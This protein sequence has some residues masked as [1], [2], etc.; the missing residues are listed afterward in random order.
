MSIEL[1]RLT[2]KFF[3]LNELQKLS[4]VTPSI[5][6]PYPLRPISEERRIVHECSR[7]LQ[8]VKINKIRAEI[9]AM[10]ADN[11]S[12]CRKTLLSEKCRLCHKIVF[13]QRKHALEPVTN[14]SDNRNVRNIVIN[15]H[16]KNKRK[17]HSRERYSNRKYRKKL[18]DFI[19]NLE[20]RTIVNLSSTD[21][22]LEDLFALEIGHGFI[23]SL[24]NRSVEEEQLILE[25]FRFIDRIGIAESQFSNQSDNRNSR[26]N[27]NC[28]LPSAQEV[29]IPL[30][31]TNSLLSDNDSRENFVRDSKRGL[32]MW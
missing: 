10:N 15:D 29:I 18:Q 17:I 25:G 21:I 31:Q 32:P 5:A 1:A 14:L 7:K 3:Y 16:R 4:M 26:R 24:G 22:P 8:E 23:L 12:L 20:N 19:D 11:I 28:S 30:S 2:S 27:E 9:A 13:L 6:K